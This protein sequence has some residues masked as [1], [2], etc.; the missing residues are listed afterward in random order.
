MHVK[1]MKLTVCVTIWHEA[2]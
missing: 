1:I 2:R